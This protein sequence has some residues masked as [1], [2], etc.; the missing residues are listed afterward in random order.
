MNKDRFTKKV[1]VVTGAARGIGKTIAQ[2]FGNEGATVIICDINK[3]DGKKALSQFTKQGI[4]AGFLPLDLSRKGVPQRL[5]KRVVKKYGKIDILVN[6]ASLHVA[7]TFLEETEES[8]RKGLSV[9]L[10]AAFF[11]SQEA[12]RAMRVG[13]G[14]SIVSIGSVK[15]ELAGSGSPIYHIAKAGLTN[16]TRYIA[17][18]AG[19]YN[20][21]VNCVSPGF[22]VQDEY[23]AR[24]DKK[25]NK[26]YRKVAEFLHPGR[27]IGESSDVASAVLY[28]CS[29]EA[30]FITGQC[31]TVDGGLTIQEQ[32]N[33]IY[34][35][36]QKND[37]V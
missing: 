19:K 26:K 20:V 21:R 2:T 37:E 5:I 31:L 7:K 35:F 27:S 22:I 33:L 30:K 32:S 17:L 8:W 13:D 28:L 25:N 18:H 3:K 23:R 1:V 9:T 10:T 12:V 36:E 14:G 29:P 4:T 11:A 16:M 6:N 15:A 24:Y 34:K